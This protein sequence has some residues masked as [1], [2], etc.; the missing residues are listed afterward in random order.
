VAAR[1]G[2]GPARREGRAARVALEQPRERGGAA[3]HLAT[4]ADLGHERLLTRFD[5]LMELLLDAV[6]RTFVETE[7]PWAERM[8]AALGSLLDLAAAHPRE[9]RLCTIEIFEAGERG[10]ELR[11]RAMARFMKLC[12]AGYAYSGVPVPSRL[13]PQVA[14]GAVFE[15]I[16]AHAGESRVDRLPDALPTAALIVLSPIVGRDEALRVAG[17]A[18][19]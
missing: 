3:L 11:D 15:L 6:E 8:H 10:R 1:P 19:D 2:R 13:M 12:E 9:A 14:A 16:R 17:V 4:P 18:P 5:A 7:G